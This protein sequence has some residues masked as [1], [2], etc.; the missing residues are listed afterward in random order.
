MVEAGYWKAGDEIITAACAFPTTVNPLLLYGLVPVFV[1]IDIGTY[2]PNYGNITEAISSKT[3]GVMQAHTLGNPFDDMIFTLAANNNIH[4][5]E[6]CCD[7]LGS[8]H[9]NV[10]GYGKNGKVHVGSRG[11]MATCSFFPAH[12]IT[13]GEGG[14]VF[15][16]DSN[17]ISITES[18]R[19][20]GRDCWCPPG[21][22]NSCGIR[23]EQQLGELPYGY[24]HS[25]TY[26]R[27]G[28]NLKTTEIAAACGLAQIGKLNSFISKRKNFFH[29]LYRELS[30]L[31]NYICLPLATA[32][33]SPSWFGFPITIKKEGERAALQ[34]YLETYKIGS[35]C[36]FSGNITR[37]PYMKGRNY[38]I[39]GSLENSDKVM[40]SSLWIGLH[41]HLTEEMLAF[42]CDKIKAFFQ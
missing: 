34:A 15:S 16:N 31:E 7:A 6:D 8:Q 3:K 21:V 32:N 14:A 41:P 29:L 36:L 5:I 1:D 26:S 25:Y 39:S 17:L 20:W 23:F 11:R 38:R 22:K 10:Y 33:S 30:G 28:F 2:N 12:H 24:D 18:I 13:T 42:V 19:D 4:I 40:N 27:L 35:R 9:E 37:H